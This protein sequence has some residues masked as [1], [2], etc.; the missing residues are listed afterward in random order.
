[1]L[2]GHSHV[3]CYALV[4][5]YAHHETYFVKRVPILRCLEELQQ[6]PMNFFEPRR[7]QQQG[8]GLHVVEAECREALGYGLVHCCQCGWQYVLFQTHCQSLAEDFIGP[9]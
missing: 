5:P 6:R 3:L 9:Y 8:C 4:K 2:P 1:V 7:L